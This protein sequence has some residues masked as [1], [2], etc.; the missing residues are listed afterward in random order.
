[1]LKKRCLSGLH[2][3][4]F[5][6]QFPMGSDVH[7][8]AGSSC[9][10]AKVLLSCAF[11]FSMELFALQLIAEAFP[12]LGSI[13]CSPGTLSVRNL[14]FS[15]WL[16]MSHQ[17]VQLFWPCCSSSQGR[18]PSLTLPSCLSPKSC[19]LRRSFHL[20]ALP[21]LLCN[22][23][24]FGILGWGNTAPGESYEG[25]GW[26]GGGER[27]Y[28]VTLLTLLSHTERNFPLLS[29]RKE[30]SPLFSFPSFWWSFAFVT[31]WLGFQASPLR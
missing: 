13:K 17:G 3:L 21:G 24:V 1:M 14:S 25:V 4:V 5:L 12:L 19:A 16:W 7:S 27:F 2:L 22:S 28:F 10:L 6:G 30:I 18:K 23:L 11:F 29:G 15:G 31:E 26:V 20:Q 8:L 9:G